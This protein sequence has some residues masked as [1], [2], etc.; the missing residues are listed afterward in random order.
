MLNFR[1]F[2]FPNPFQTGG[3]VS[4]DADLIVRMWKEGRLAELYQQTD[5]DSK[6]AEPV[7]ITKNKN[8]ANAILNAEFVEYGVSNKAIQTGSSQIKKKKDKIEKLLC[9]VI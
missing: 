5:I 2:G 1:S 4:K 7:D 3:I 8:N 6:D 9:T